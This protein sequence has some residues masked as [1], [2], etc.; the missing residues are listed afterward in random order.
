M[1]RLL[2]RS[3]FSESE[4]I[5]ARTQAQTSQA[6]CADFSCTNS[7]KSSAASQARLLRA[8]MSRLLMRRLI[9][10][11]LM[12]RLLMRMFFLSGV[13]FCT[14][15]F[16]RSRSRGL[17]VAASFVKRAPAMDKVLSRYLKGRA[18]RLEHS[19][20]T[21]EVGPSATNA[22]LSTGDPRRA[23]RPMHSRPSKWKHSIQRNGRSWERILNRRMQT[24]QWP[25]HSTAPLESRENPLEAQ[26][27]I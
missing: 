14:Y 24:W 19:A 23:R 3:F 16:L 18:R 26:H 15:L 20:L 17:A 13:L 11:E 5:S 4:T 2:V 9:Q 22:K 6:L 27:A 1:R 12:R 8:L 10:L 21:G 7:L 25:S